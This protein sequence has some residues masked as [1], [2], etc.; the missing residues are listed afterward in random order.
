MTANS[1]VDNNT[2]EC[3][4]IVADGVRSF[5]LL[6][7][8]MLIK[9]NYQVTECGSGAECMKLSKEMHP[10]LIII[11]NTLPDIA[12]LKLIS[13]MRDRADTCNIPLMLLYPDMDNYKATG[14]PYQA[15]A[16]DFMVCPIKWFVLYARLRKLAALSETRHLMP[17]R[18]NPAEK[19]I[20]IVDSMISIVLSIK[21]LLYSRGYRTFFQTENNEKCIEIAT[22]ELPDL[23]VVNA[24]I[25][26]NNGLDVARKLKSTNAISHIPIV[27]ISSLDSESDY[28]KAFTAGVNDYITI[29]YNKEELVERIEH[30]LRVSEATN[31]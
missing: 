25:W 5:Q 30:V 15:G 7:K 27:F 24:S 23:I 8:V 16:D 6:L 20:L 10:T 29:P 13:Q 9:E 11:G 3:K 1:I 4:V 19:K 2:K 14:L 21:I 22:K 18:I 28:S 26:N 31:S 17:K 12:V